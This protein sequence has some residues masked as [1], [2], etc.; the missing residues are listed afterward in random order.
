MRDHLLLLR[1]S[2]WVHFVGEEMTDKPLLPKA[3]GEAAAIRMA[4]REGQTLNE[5]AQAISD[6]AREYA[7]AQTPPAYEKWAHDH[8]EEAKALVEGRALVLMPPMLNDPNLIYS[9]TCS[10]RTTKS[11]NRDGEGN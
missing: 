1:V 2:R 7:E 3:A 6:F 4:I 8:P 9:V 11:E 5:T 10:K